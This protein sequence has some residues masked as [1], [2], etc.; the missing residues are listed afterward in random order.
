MHASAASKALPKQVHLR[1]HE[2]EVTES[3][4]LSTLEPGPTAI[5]YKACAVIELNTSGIVADRAMPV[6]GSVPK[7]NGAI[8][9]LAENLI[10]VLT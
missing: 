9:V 7:P 1:Q 8:V 6:F 3:C 10:T 4:Q 5:L 2:G